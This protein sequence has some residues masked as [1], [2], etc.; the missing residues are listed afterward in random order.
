MALNTMNDMYG[1]IDMPFQGVY[2]GSNIKHPKPEAAQWTKI[3]WDSEVMPWPEIIQEPKALP[4][5]EISKAFSL[6]KKCST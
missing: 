3:I 6:Q 5:A 2:R 4:R 1:M